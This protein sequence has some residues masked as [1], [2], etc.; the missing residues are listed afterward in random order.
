MQMSLVHWLSWGNS[1]KNGW[2]FRLLPAWE[3]HPHMSLVKREAHT[4]EM[5]YM[6]S[7]WEK[8]T[9]FLS[10]SIFQTWSDG[11][12]WHTRWWKI[13]F[14][15]FQKCE[16]MNWLRC[17]ITSTRKKKI[18]ETKIERQIFCKWFFPLET[19][20]WLNYK[21]QVLWLETELLHLM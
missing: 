12:P 6:G 11:P 7:T 2:G 1:L 5:L 3:N 16:G 18:T 17:N 20:L 4:W 15:C 8:S 14:L 13:C 9:S 19:W 10:H 21:D